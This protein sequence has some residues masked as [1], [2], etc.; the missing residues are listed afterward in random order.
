MME[1]TLT[2]D[3]FEKIISENKTVLIDFW[4]SWCG[5][6]KMIAPHVK[7]LS[8]EL[9]DVLVCKA[10]VDEEAELAVMFGVNSIPT[11][12]LIKDGKDQNR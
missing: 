7:R 3:N 8:E 6:C 1:I 9:T 2:K 11:L 12:V 4:A 10:N 5:P